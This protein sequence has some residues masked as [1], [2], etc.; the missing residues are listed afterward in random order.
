[1][2]WGGG[3]VSCKVEVY[4]RGAATH[5]LGDLMRLGMRTFHPQPSP[6]VI[7]KTRMQT[8]KK[9]R[10][11]HLLAAYVLFVWCVVKTCDIL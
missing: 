4:H 5:F 7:G 9:D 8:N 3:W 1:M 2:R 10:R 6:S 11:D